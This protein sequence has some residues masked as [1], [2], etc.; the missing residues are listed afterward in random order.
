[1]TS[2]RADQLARANALS[3]LSSANLTMLCDFLYDRTGMQ[4]GE[5]KRYYIDRRIA[6]RMAHRHL[7]AFADYYALLRAEADEAEQL[8]NSFTINETYFYRED[9]QLAC[10]SRSILPEIVASK[11]PGDK[12]RI[13]SVP[14]SSGEEPYS[15][16]I[17]LLENWALV[18]AYNVEIVGSDIDTAIV[19]EA[20]EAK[21]GRRAVMRL[22]PELIGRYFEPIEDGRVRL[23]DDLRESVTFA[24]CNI[25]DA[26]SVARQ[27]RFDV[28]FCRN[29][30]IY[31]DGAAR[32]RCMENL[33]KSLLPGGYMCLGHSESMSR[34]SANFITRRFPDAIVYQRPEQL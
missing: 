9:H 6:D 22:S 4:F 33:L 3:P 8:I 20:L 19:A 18:D 25:T 10:L 23:I 15:I 24:P 12:I 34:I 7:T 31:F 21:Y 27:G 13:W 5:S 17:W 28:I 30:L 29:L 2:R 1:M 32:V 26:A 16:A 11:R 14:C